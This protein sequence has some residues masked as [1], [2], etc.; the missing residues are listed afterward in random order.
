MLRPLRLWRVEG[1]FVRTSDERERE[2]ERVSLYVFVCKGLCKGSQE[3]NKLF[4]SGILSL[5]VCGEEEEVCVY[6]CISCSFS[7]H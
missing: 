7:I 1:L 3:F 4:L 5:G 6:V 2:R